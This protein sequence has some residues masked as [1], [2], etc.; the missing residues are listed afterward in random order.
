MQVN[1]RQIKLRKLDACVYFYKKIKQGFVLIELLI[2]ILISTLLLNLLMKIYLTS[3]SVLQWQTALIQIQNNANEI[4]SLLNSNIKKSGHIGCA[5]LTPEFS[6]TPF[7]HYSLSNKNK[8]I[9]DDNEITIR[10]ADYPSATLLKA[11]ENE[12]QLMVS[13][14]IKFSSGDIVLISNCKWAEIFQVAKVKVSRE[15]QEIIS[16][17][18]LKH[19]F[20]LN[21]EISHFEVAHYYIDKTNRTHRD[22]SYIYAL[23]VE[24]NHERKSEL[25]SGINNINFKYLIYQQGILMEKSASQIKDW[26]CVQG[27]S[28]ELISVY[29]PLKKIWYGYVSLSK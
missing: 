9:G 18:S 12:W 14:N 5:K 29:P 1:A 13:R 4:I 25:V 23:Y 8:L 20:D 15:V 24:N 2:A 22:G 28:Y 10:Y 21:S 17:S 16:T 3:E 11:M 7:H 26:S 27:V 19:R 6:A